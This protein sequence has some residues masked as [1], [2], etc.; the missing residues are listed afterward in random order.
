MQFNPDKC[1]IVRND[2]RN[3][4]M[5]KYHIHGTQLQTVKDAKYPGVTISSDLSW[6]KH[7]DNTVEKAT[8]SLNFL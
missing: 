3:P 5:H 7:V 4:L 2:K 8:T 1:E 6:N